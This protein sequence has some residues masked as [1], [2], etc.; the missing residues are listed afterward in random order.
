ML[1]F[2]D[3]IRLSVIMDL[4]RIIKDIDILNKNKEELNARSIFFHV[5]EQDIHNIYILIIGQHKQEDRYTSPYVGGFFLFHMSMSDEYPLVPPKITFHPKQ[6]F[7]RIH[8]NYYKCGKVC[9]SV[10]NSWGQEDWTPATSIL[11]LINILEVRFNEKPLCFEP[12]YE[13]SNEA[14]I[15]LYNRCVKFGV[16]TACIVSVLKKTH[17]EF[18]IFDDVIASYFLKHKEAYVRSV[19][20]EAEGDALSPCYQEQFR[21]S[22]RDILRFFRGYGV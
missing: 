13:M 8:P 10:I 21:I 2:K 12:C 14:S 16:N 15:Q 6:N 9:L 11:S 22:Y 19:E 1:L 20:H 3:L 4:K 17:K 7:A 18:C 5:D